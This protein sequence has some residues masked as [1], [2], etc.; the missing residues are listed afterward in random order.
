ML[1]ADSSL[2]D[3]ADDLTDAARQLAQGRSTRL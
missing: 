3:I 1:A 2:D